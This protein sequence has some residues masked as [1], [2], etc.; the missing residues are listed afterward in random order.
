MA[1]WYAVQTKP[2][3]EQVALANLSRQDYE[4]F[5]PM[6]SV[7]RRRRGR[8]RE[9]AEPLFPGYLFTRLDLRL[10]NT[11]PIRSTR[12][13]TGLVRFGGEP[14]P[15]PAGIIRG[16]QEAGAG[17]GGFIRP[18][19]VLN[20]GDPVEIVAGPLAGLRGIFLANSG[21]ERVQIL[22]DLVGHGNRA[23]VSRDQL[24]PATSQ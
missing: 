8:W 4:T 10:E 21:V 3:K 14:R 23:T 6:I 15:V 9:I 24:A 17:R 11:A 7:Q 22:L 13:V 16:L 2:R 1:D 18:E 12:G 20:A 5:L 19:Q